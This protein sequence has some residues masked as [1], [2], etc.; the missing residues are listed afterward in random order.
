MAELLSALAEAKIEAE[1]N[2]EVIFQ[3]KQKIERRDS[4][5]FEG[6]LYFRELRNKVKDGP[7]CQKC[8][9]AEE[10]FMRTH[11]GQAFI[12]VR[13]EWSAAQICRKCGS[14]HALIT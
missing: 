10:L 4:V 11:E 6:G 9:D 1:E 14:I 2:A 8:Y 13:Q 5:V 3:L 12:D 7:F